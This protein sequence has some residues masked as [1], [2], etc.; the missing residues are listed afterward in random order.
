MCLTRMQNIEN[1][2]AELHIMLLVR[3]EMTEVQIF[4]LEDKT[5]MEMSMT[6]ENHRCVQNWEE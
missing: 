4:T 2:I 1:E 3:T 5:I 6:S